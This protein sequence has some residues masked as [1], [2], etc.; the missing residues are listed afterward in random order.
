MTKTNWLA[1]VGVLVVGCA[2]IESETTLEET[3]TVEAAIQC[4]DDDED[5]FEV[6]FLGCTEVAALAILPYDDAR[7]LVPAQYELAGDG[8]F[9]LMVVR[10]ANCNNVKI[11]GKSTGESTVAQVG[12]TI[13]PPDGDGDINNYTVHYDTD[14]KKLAKKL[15][16]AGVSK[17]RYVSKLDYDLD[18][19]AGT[20]NINVPKPSKARYQV[21]ASIIAPSSPGVPFVANWWEAGE[22][23]EVTKMGTAIP[24]IQF[25]TSDTTLTV[26]PTSTLVDLIGG[27]VLTEFPALDSFNVFPSAHMV[28]DERD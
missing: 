7:P 22:D 25:G 23:G 14:G 28:V 10:I 18:L 1:A 3:N 9:A 27:T 6:D 19:G 17:A 24:S 15:N 26:H 21:T 20:L 12:I 16:D 4:N 13:V 2:G 8:T 5:D 11:D